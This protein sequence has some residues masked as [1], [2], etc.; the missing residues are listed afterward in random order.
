MLNAWPVGSTAHW[1]ILDTDFGGGQH[2]LATWQTW[3]AGTEPSVSRPSLLHYC[4]FTPQAPS[5]A[6][7]LNHTASSPELTALAETLAVQWHGLQPGFHRISLEGGH[8]LLTLCV[9]ELKA[10]LRELT[11][12]ADS[13]VLAGIGKSW[14]IHTVKAI[15][16]CCQRGTRIVA[17]HV[18]ENIQNALLQCGFV[19]GEPSLHS[20]YNPPWEPKKR[21][22]VSQPV[23]IGTCAVIGAGLAGAAVA[24]SLARRGWQV[25]VLD[26]A[27]QPAQGASGIPAGL[28]VPHV[29]PDDSVLSRLSRSG[30]RITLQ[31]A[32]ALLVA[33]VDWQCSGVLEH[34]V[35]GSPGLP[36]HAEIDMTW[37]RP[38]TT[39]QL[40]AAQLSSDDKAIW[41]DYAAWIKP[42]ALVAALLKH[43]NISLQANSHV[44]SMQSIQQSIQVKDTEME[45]A[46]WQLRDEAGKLLA[47]AQL[48]VV[49]AAYAS[50]HLVA[51][52]PLQAIRG[53]ISW[54]MHPRTPLQ[55]TPPHAPFPPFP[56]NGYGSLIPWIPMAEGM[57][58]AVG[59][60]FERDQADTQSSAETT[61]HRHADNQIRLSKL[62]PR[63][64]TQFSVNSANS[65][66]RPASHAF[67]GIRCVSPDR[68]PMSGPLVTLTYKK[69]LWLSTAMGSRGLSFA[70]LCAELLAA[71]LHGEPW[72]IEKRLGQALDPERFT[73]RPKK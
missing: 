71:R 41:H 73:H 31:Q 12:T 55:V 40:H 48:V 43:P 2:F 39:A 6:T 29:S 64:A 16:R 7:L 36:T 54:G 27:A 19:Q 22:T 8:V 56:V 3:K 14:D 21:S 46:Q 38:A 66:N 18:P 53:Q 63:V 34:R 65:V 10:V 35:D 45:T 59:A 49:A 44:S 32:Q 1:R 20:V 33:G 26:A 25:T 60:T 4:A 17:E 57:A 30:V 67:V 52:L 72:P 28:A 50:Q 58:W 37:S 42:A 11:F 62:L 51:A 61:A 68:L 5:A 70:L 9:G 69:D 23:Q 13:V 15:A 24:N 47:Q